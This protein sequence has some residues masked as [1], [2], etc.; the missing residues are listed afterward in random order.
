M[1]RYGIDTSIFV[2]LLTGDPER[3]YQRIL[4]LLLG[5]IDDDPA[6]EILVSNQV[7]GESYVALQH[8]YGVTKPEARTAM[9]SVFD[10]GL[11][12]PANGASTLEQLRA[13]TGA[14]LLDRL[15][16]EDYLAMGAVTLTLDQRMARLEGAQTL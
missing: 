1:A 16:H 7:V 13:K 6:T 14:G 15:I 12:A 10:S 9:L 4:R 3:E 11:V 2:R 5:L 8:H